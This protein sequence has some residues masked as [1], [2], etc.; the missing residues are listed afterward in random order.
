MSYINFA[1]VNRLADILTVAEWLEL[2]VKNNRSRCPHNDGDKREMSFSTEKGMYRCWSCD[3][4]G[5][6]ISLTAHVLKLSMK[7]AALAM[8]KHFRNYVPD[9]RGLPDT[10]LDY[11]EPK[12]PTV[13][14][15]GMGE[16]TATRIGIG[17]A[18]RGTMIKHVLFPLR[19]QTGK[20]LG[21][22]GYNPETKALKL[23]KN[24]LE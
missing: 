1:E 13:Q 18:P 23:P 22:L 17:H 6:A 5:D 15:L 19:D 7:D 4:K 3:Y 24:M 20:L 9:K 14:A 12:H 21:Y 11:L 10:G 16:K 8:E 2:D